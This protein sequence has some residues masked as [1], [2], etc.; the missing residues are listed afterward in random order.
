[1]GPGRKQSA[2]AV[3]LGE[4]DSDGGDARRQYNERSTDGGLGNGTAALGLSRGRARRH[5]PINNVSADRSRNQA[6]EPTLL[7]C[8]AHA[9]PRHSTGSRPAHCYLG[10]TL[11]GRSGRPGPG[12]SVAAAM[13]RSGAWRLRIT[14]DSRMDGVCAF[15]PSVTRPGFDSNRAVS[16]PWSAGYDRPNTSAKRRYDSR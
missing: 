2:D 15:I 8:R 7:P 12:S 13:R 14:C 10:G 1:M 3:R 9:S 4:V 16:R 11:R 6:A 5:R